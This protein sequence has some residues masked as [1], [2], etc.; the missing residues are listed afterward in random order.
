[1]LV[2]RY[3][4]ASLIVTNYT[5]VASQPWYGEGEEAIAHKVSCSPLALFMF[6][7]PLTV[8]YPRLTDMLREV[9]SRFSAL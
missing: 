4:R 8:T 9:Y 2:A 6:P 7:S 1:M 5:L 3:L